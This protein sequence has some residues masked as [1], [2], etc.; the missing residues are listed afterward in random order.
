[1]N[2]KMAESCHFLSNCLFVSHSGLCS[3][4][5]NILARSPSDYRIYF[6]SCLSCTIDSLCIV[7]LFSRIVI[8]DAPQSFLCEFQFSQHI[9]SVWRAVS[10][11][12]FFSSHGEEYKCLFKTG[13]VEMTNRECL[14]KWSRTSH[15]RRIIQDGAKCDWRTFRPARGR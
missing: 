13:H 1:M 3:A 6:L 2:S 14:L 10:A 5:V 15:K 8:F 7:G 11:V 4:F 9:F 12:S